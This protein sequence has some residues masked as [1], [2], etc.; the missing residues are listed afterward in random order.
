MTL[1]T[2]RGS[3]HCG[4]V[5]YEADI[6]LAAGTGQCNCTFRTKIRSWNALVKPS[7]FRLLSGADDLSDYQFGQKVGHHTFCPN[8]GV[9]PFSHG[10]LEVL[11]GDFVSIAIAC[12]DDVEPSELAEL[13][14]GYAD[15]RNNAWWNQPHGNPPP[16]RESE[17]WPSS[18][19]ARSLDRGAVIFRSIRALRIAN[20]WPSQPLIPDH[21]EMRFAHSSSRSAGSSLA[22]IASSSLFGG[23][24]SDP[25]VSD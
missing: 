12:L 3:C 23:S 5:R 6:D 1:K 4:A 24:L 16:L 9:R 13:P 7:A 19:P 10:Q 18:G 25:T 21:R 14:V 8:C 2:Y 15:G 17:A 20:V 11:G 22:S